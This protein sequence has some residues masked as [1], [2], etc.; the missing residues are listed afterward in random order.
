M[1][2]IPDYGTNLEYAPAVLIDTGESAARINPLSQMN[3]S[4]RVIYWDY[5]A[6][7]N[8]WHKTNAAT[9]TTPVLTGVNCMRI[10]P[11]TP[12]FSGEAIKGFPYLFNRQS[13]GMEICFAIGT[14]LDAIHFLF[15]PSV[16][17][18]SYQ[19]TVNYN[20]STG[21]WTFLGFAI[22]TRLLSIYSAANPAWN[23][24]KIVYNTRT[25]RGAYMSINGY[26]YEID[27]G[28]L[29]VAS[30][31]EFVRCGVSADDAAG[32]AFCYLDNFILT[33]D[34]PLTMPNN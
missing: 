19:M 10:A 1:K 30:I 29:G 15:T 5:F 26:Y 25:M 20:V 16:L 4:G 9:Q 34:E 13:W 17:T 3:R 7:T 14:G 6:S 18:E 27:R 24:V 12:S 33:I 11:V 23:H 2:T 28:A 8:P 32:A 21:A 22:T 31:G